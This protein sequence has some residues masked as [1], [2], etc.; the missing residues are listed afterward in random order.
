MTL[1]ASSRLEHCTPR[2]RSKQHCWASGFPRHLQR[3]TRRVFAQ[4]YGGFLKWGYPK[5]LCFFFRENPK[6]IHG[7]FRGSTLGHLHDLGT[8]WIYTIIQ[9]YTPLY[10]YIFMQCVCGHDFISI[11]RYGSFFRGE[12]FVRGIPPKKNSIN[13]PTK[14]RKF[15][16]IRVAGL[17]W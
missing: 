13:K 16:E 1:D 10:T 11:P 14:W 12:P 6:I 3:C 5:M 8:I 7:W 9:Y 4:T 2:S 15:M 17:F